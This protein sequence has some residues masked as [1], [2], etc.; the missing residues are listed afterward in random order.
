[1]ESVLIVED[2]GSLRDTLTRFLRREEHDLISAADGRAAFDSVISASPDVLGAYG[3]C[4]S[5][6][7]FGLGAAFAKRRFW[8]FS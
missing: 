7:A 6:K 3:R 4:T 1:M 8:L 5:S 2:E